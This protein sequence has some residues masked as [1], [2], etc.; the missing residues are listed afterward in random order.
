MPTLSTNHSF[1][2]LI[3]SRKLLTKQVRNCFR[4]LLSLQFNF[5]SIDVGM[6][7]KKSFKFDQKF[8]KI[9]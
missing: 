9:D 8:I 7:Q 4:H 6:G 3:F 2:S 5:I 1:Q